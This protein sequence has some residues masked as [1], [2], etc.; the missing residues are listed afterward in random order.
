[1]AFSRELRLDPLDS[2]MAETL[3]RGWPKVASGG[4][5]CA[6]GEERADSRMRVCIFHH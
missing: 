3:D 6:G 5:L 4:H 2:H 1:M